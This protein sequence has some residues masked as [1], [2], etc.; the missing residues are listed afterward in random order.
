MPNGP[1]ASIVLFLSEATHGMELLADSSAY[2]SQAVLPSATSAH[3]AASSES[4][5]VPSQDSGQCST[6]PGIILVFGL[7]L[8]LLALVWYVVCESG[9]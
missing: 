1:A 6:F 3:G 7:F 8:I 4:T 9:I 2:C 5:W